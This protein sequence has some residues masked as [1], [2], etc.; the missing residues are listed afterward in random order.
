VKHLLEGDANTKYFQLLANGRQENTIF[1]LQDESQ[2]I[3][4]GL[5]LKK[6][7]TTY[8]KGLFER[9]VR[10]GWMRGVGMIFPR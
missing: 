9:R 6:Y 5:E 3:C 1:Q 2:N 10:S 4:G 8:Y 7:I